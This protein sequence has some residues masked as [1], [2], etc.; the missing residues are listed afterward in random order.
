MLHVITATTVVG[1]LSKSFPIAS[2]EVGD[3]PKNGFPAVMKKI[4]KLL[5]ERGFKQVEDRGSS[6]VINGKTFI[7]LES[8]PSIEDR[9]ASARFDLIHTVEKQLSPF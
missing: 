7:S 5:R 2:V 6:L 1:S 4:Q 9:E 3:G 8:L